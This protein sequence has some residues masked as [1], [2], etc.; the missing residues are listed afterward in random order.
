[1]GRNDMRLIYKV[2]C[3]LSR[4]LME[5][6]DRACEITGYEQA[7]IIRACLNSQLHTLMAI[8]G[9]IPMLQTGILKT[10]PQREEVGK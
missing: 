8:P 9:L 10:T 3:N 1:M 5:L 7:E 6:L 4:E 2:N